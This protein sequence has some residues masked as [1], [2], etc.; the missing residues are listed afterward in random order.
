MATRRQ[1]LLADA[2][3]SLIPMAPL[4]DTTEIRALANREHMRGL[5]VARAIWLATVTH[6]RHV[7]TDYHAL[8]ADGYDRDAARHFIIEDTNAVLGAWGSRH[9][10][11]ADDPAMDQD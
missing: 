10:L 1:T 8:L 2:L 7:H 3:H 5:P 6:I 9:R 11:N 4:S